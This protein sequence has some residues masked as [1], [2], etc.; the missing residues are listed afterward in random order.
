M[1][2]LDTLLG[3]DDGQLDTVK[4]PYEFSDLFEIFIDFHGS[5][6]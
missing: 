3:I 6:V 2:S 4:L 1:M 5:S